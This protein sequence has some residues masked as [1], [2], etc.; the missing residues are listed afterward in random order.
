M[1]KAG[2]LGLIVPA[3]I[4]EHIDRLAFDQVDPAHRGS[5]HFH[6]AATPGGWRANLTAE[7]QNL[8]STVL[9]GVRSAYALKSDQK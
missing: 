6:R 8:L 5:G 1:S 7:E 2:W 3:G 4:T 9:N